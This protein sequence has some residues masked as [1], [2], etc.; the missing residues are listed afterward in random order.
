MSVNSRTV[1]VG[2]LLTSHPSERVSPIFPEVMRLLADRGA[3]V[4]VIHPDE[5][6][7]DLRSL[8][9]A[10]DLYVL[11]AKTDTAL[12]LA[13]ALHSAGAAILNPYPVS[14]ACR[15]RTVLGHLL[16]D[17]GIPVP[18]TWA[19][20]DPVQFAHLLKDGPIVVKPNR[21]SQGRGVRVVHVADELETIVAGGPFVAQR[22]HRPTGRDRKLY[23]IGD[24]MF[25]V[26]RVWPVRTYLDKLGEPFTANDEL[27]DIAMRCG[28]A[29][30][31]GLYGLD[32][33]DTE[34]GP[35]VVDLSSLPGFKGVPNAARLLAR[36]V[37]DVAEQAR[38]GD[39]D[40][41]A[42]RSVISVG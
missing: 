33:V 3:R 42:P 16:R 27:R 30:G 23:R 13:G 14:A 28:T 1:S 9:V 25:G 34:D 31:I 5:T 20:T 24:R 8:H 39:P 29:L 11:K 35:Y 6:L 22:Y 36:Y 10:H 21:G 37:W 2:F 26:K 38:A 19:A 18:A 7:I 17:A 40:F 4:D 15:D 12:S 32:V 41:A